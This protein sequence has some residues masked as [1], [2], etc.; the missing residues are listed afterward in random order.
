MHIPVYTA[1][2]IVGHKDISQ[3]MQDGVGI[4]KRMIKPHIQLSNYVHFIKE[5]SKAGVIIDVV[6]IILTSQMVFI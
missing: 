3:S 1:N 5:Y 6:I 4:S 2:W